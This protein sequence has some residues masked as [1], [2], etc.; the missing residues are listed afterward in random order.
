MA[1]RK[2]IDHLIGRRFGRWTI[3][4]EVPPPTGYEYQR[5]VE[6]TCDCGRRRDVYLQNLT[7]GMSKSCGCLKDERTRVRS[8]T[9]GMSTR[10]E[11]RIW[12]S[13]KR[14]CY[15]AKAKGF[16]NYGGRGI[17]VCTRWRTGFA[18]F[19]SDV[20]PRPSVQYSLDRIN[21]DGNYEPGNVRWA[22]RTQQSNNTR[23]NHVLVVDGDAKTLTEWANLVGLKPH[24]IL[25]RL[26]RG[27]DI[28]AAINTG[29]LTNTTRRAN[30]YLTLHGHTHCV[31]EWAHRT[32]LGSGTILARLR[33]GWSVERALMTPA[34]SY[35]R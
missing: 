28:K 4:R 34:R 29:Q 2:P 6:A 11:Y 16:E 22:T 23:D 14:R 13:M 26:S 12:T 7:R 3:V 9:H 35:K 18:A 27:W 24:A 8:R 1:I 19:F 10:P 30:R 17:A 20:G 32:G 31:S 33:V 5:Y 25:H 15:D 21:N